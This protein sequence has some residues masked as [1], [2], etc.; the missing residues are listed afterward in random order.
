M[1]PVGLLGAS[2]E[3][4]TQDLIAASARCQLSRIMSGNTPFT[5]MG[6]PI[7]IAVIEL[8]HRLVVGVRFDG[9]K[10]DQTAAGGIDA[11]LG[12]RP[13]KTRRVRLGTRK[14]R[15]QAQWPR[16]GAHDVRRLVDPGGDVRLGQHF[17]RGAGAKAEKQQ[18]AGHGR[19]WQSPRID[20]F[21]PHSRSIRR[22]NP[23]FPVPVAYPLISR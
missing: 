1:P 14:L 5:L 20:G 4:G 3:T 9:D 15:W 13:E 16:Q 7:E 11:D 18:G 6:R 2:A 10:G 8:H 19:A 17:G 12:L 21:R 22:A 23:D